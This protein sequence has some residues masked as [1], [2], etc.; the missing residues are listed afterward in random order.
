MEPKVFEI[1]LNDL[2]DKYNPTNKKEIENI[3]KKYIGQ[4]LDAVYY[5]L[6]KYNYP[7]H[8]NYDPNLSD[9]N[10]IRQLFK[11]Y[12][13]GNRSLT[14]GNHKISIEEQLK[15]NIVKETETKLQNTTEQLS[16]E[17]NRHIQGMKNEIEALRLIL[18][19]KTINQPENKTSFEIKLNILY[20]ESELILPKEIDD[21]SIGTRFLVRDTAGKLIALEVKD[22][23]YDF[24]STDSFVKEITIDRV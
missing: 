13:D 11:E 9:M 21:F 16:R 6:T 24:I 2:Y 20:S 8:P 19:E 18:K 5:F 15:S 23:F 12:L 3:T 1:L 17:I 14:K 10:N 4:E 22:I 7:K